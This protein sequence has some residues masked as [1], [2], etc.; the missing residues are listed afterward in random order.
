MDWLGFLPDISL[1]ENIDI[2]IINIGDDVEGDLVEGDVIEG[3]AIDGDQIDG[4]YVLK[5]DGDIIPI[6]E[7]KRVIPGELSGDAPIDLRKNNREL[8]IDPE[9]FEN[10]DE[11][12]DVVKPGLKAGWKHEGAVSTQ[13]A[14][15][16]LLQAERNITDEKISDIKQFFQDKIFS[17]DYLLLQSSLTID[18][19]MN[20]EEGARMTDS[21]LRERK[22]NL[23]EKY[24]EGAYSLPSMCTSGYFD[25]DQL[26]RQ[27]FQKMGSNPDYNT[28][29]YKSVFRELVISKPFVV[30]VNETQSTEEL[31]DV[32]RG[33]ITRLPNDDIP[34]PYLDI[35]GIGRT[36]HQKIRQAMENI[37]D[38]YN[39]IEYDE[40]LGGEELVIRI[41]ADSIS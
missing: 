17:S 1:P 16:I 38:E 15:P 10:E 5:S 2:D 26:F 4:E 36:N 24:H 7:I 6:N 3:D 18:R 20:A 11:W 14:Y 30:Y 8:V 21:E 23:A 27:I 29:N 19:A 37:N 9:N 39:R 12:E 28:N 13:S 40:R 22:R 41:D 25:E 32:I 34:L 35:R 31:V 33:K